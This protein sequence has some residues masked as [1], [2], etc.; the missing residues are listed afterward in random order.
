M[1]TATLAQLDAAIFAALGALQTDQ[2]TGPTAGKPF[3]LVGRY[4]GA[5]TPRGVGSQCNAQYPAALLRWSDEFAERDVDITLAG[6][7]EDRGRSLWTVLVVVEDP[8]AIDD[9]MAGAT[10]VPGVFTLVD[11]VLGAC[12]ALIIAGTWHERRLR[13]VRAAPSAPLTDLGVTYAAEVTF[14]AARVAPAAATTDASVPLTSLVGDVNLSGFDNTGA[15]DPF[16]T[17][18]ATT[19]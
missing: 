13:Y 6:D 12:N 16:E 15:P 1:A 4:A 8:R 3:A 2:T 9:G 18:Q 7:A 14:E 17:F 19:A 5:F 11:A 10:G